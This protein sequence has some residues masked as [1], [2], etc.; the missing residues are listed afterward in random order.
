MG[1]SQTGKLNAR[2]AMEFCFAVIMLGTKRAKNVMAVPGG[3][4]LSEFI[5]QPGQAG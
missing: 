1:R 5:K 2:S 4:F 3:H